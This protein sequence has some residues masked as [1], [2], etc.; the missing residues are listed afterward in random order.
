MRDLPLFLGQPGE[1]ETVLANGL[2]IIVP[3]VDQRHVVAMQR[4][5]PAHVTADGAATEHHD[6][7][8]HYFL[9]HLFVTSFVGL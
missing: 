4:Q 6:T 7:L 9:P 3:E 8:T 5:M 2:D 1:L